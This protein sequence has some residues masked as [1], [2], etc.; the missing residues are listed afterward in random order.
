MG[1]LPTNLLP[2]RSWRPFLVLPQKN[3]LTSSCV[4][5][6]ILGTIFPDFSGILQGISDILPRFSE[7]LHRFWTNQNFWGYACTPVPYTTACGP[8]RKNAVPNANVYN[9]KKISSCL[10]KQNAIFDVHFALRL[11]IPYASL[12]NL[13]FHLFLARRY[14]VLKNM[15]YQC[16][17]ALMKKATV[18][19]IFNPAAVSLLKTNRC[20][21]QVEFESDWIEFGNDWIGQVLFV[22]RQTASSSLRAGQLVVK[23]AHNQTYRLVQE[24]LARSRR[25]TVP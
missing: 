12:R 7:N 25:S 22:K 13:V 16:S 10:H 5:L 17:F 23:A 15:R 19:F 18:A 20:C 11:G 4:F 21:L 2:Q 14:V 8:S 24:L 6:Q 9:C 1:L 3:V